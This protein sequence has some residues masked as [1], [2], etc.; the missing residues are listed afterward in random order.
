[1]ESLKQYLTMDS[2]WAQ[3]WRYR[4]NPNHFKIGFHLYCCDENQTVN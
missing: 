3:L 2:I 1:M 4:W